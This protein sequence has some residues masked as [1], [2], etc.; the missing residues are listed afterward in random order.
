MDCVS[1]KK[2]FI[3]WMKMMLRMLLLHMKSIHMKIKED[4]KSV[5]QRESGKGIMELLQIS[6]DQVA[7]SNLIKTMQIC[8]WFLML[9]K[10]MNGIEVRIILAK[11]KC[12]D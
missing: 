9:H 1:R 3:A 12:L 8:I 6:N 2:I 4:G 10:M 5:E 11:F 7:S